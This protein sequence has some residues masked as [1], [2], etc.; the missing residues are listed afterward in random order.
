V[1]LHLAKPISIITQ[2]DGSEMTPLLKPLLMP[3]SSA[4]REARQAFQVD[5]RAAAPLGGALYAIDNADSHRLPGVAG[6]WAMLPVEPGRSPKSMTRLL[7]H[8][9]A[10][11]RL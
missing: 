8:S 6:P 1:P 2:V 3:D 10:W 9:V 11:K 4:I 7:L 5:D